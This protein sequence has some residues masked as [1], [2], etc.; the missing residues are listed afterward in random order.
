MIAY[1]DLY[2]FSK[3]LKN[4]FNLQYPVQIIRTTLPKDK[5]GECGLTNDKFIIK[6]KKSL[7]EYYSIDVLIHEYGHALSWE[8]EKDQH[9]LEWGKAYS[10]IYRKFL[11][12]INGKN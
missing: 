7:P 4:N 6:I 2:S 1:K 11:E 9:G 8:K 12:W 3:F 10:K 5:D